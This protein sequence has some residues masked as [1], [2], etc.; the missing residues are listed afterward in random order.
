MDGENVSKP[1]QRIKFCI[2]NSSMLGYYLQELPLKYSKGTSGDRIATEQYNLGC[3]W[4]IGM[5]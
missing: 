5:F 4:Q 1:W 3:C 2:Q